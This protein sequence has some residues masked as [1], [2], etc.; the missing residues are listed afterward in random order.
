LLE[1]VESVVTF[2]QDWAAF[3]L[4][5]CRVTG[6]LSETSQKL[7]SDQNDRKDELIDLH[8]QIRVHMAEQFCLKGMVGV[9][10]LA[11]FCPLLW[12]SVL[13]LA[14]GIGLNHASKKIVRSKIKE[15]KAEERRMFRIVS[16]SALMT[17]L[18]QM[19]NMTL[20]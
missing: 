3:R 17:C 6:Q 8:L 2:E 12:D 5:N 11:A 1:L 14:L 13:L 9:I 7:Q 10:A 19:F 4:R 16:S 18:F 15:L 20:T